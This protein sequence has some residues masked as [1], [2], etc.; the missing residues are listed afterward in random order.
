MA[1]NIKLNT[2]PKRVFDAIASLREKKDQGSETLKLIDK[3]LVEAHDYVV[4]LKLEK[5]LVY[6]HEVME[7]R[8]KPEGG[9][10]KKKQLRF[11]KKMEDSVVETREYVDRNGLERW[12]SRIHRFLGRVSDY[13]EEYSQAI[14]HY[15]K[16]I[17]FTKKDPEYLQEKIPHWLEYEALLAYSTLMSGKGK[18]GLSLSRSVYKKFDNTKEG[19]FLKK[20]DYPTWAIWK[21]GIPI[22]LGFWFVE[23]KGEFDKKELLIWLNEA[24]KLLKSPKISGRWLGKVDFGFRL[25]E[26]VSIKRRIGRI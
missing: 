20:K 5:A 6:Q 15:N 25:D 7:D 13:K 14:T 10:D 23:T 17:T 1:K 26:I 8:S 18:E 4:K 22:R 9:Q 3:A 24:E 21:T 12:E 16:A 11:M 2:S 19:R